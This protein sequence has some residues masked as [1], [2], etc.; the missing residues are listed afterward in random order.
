[1]PARKFDR[2]MEEECIFLR[3]ARKGKQIAGE[4]SDLDEDEDGGRNGLL[5]LLPDME[6]VKNQGMPYYHPQVSGLAFHYVPPVG[7][8]INPATTSNPKQQ[9]VPAAAA[10]LGI[11]SLE[12]IS[13]P[14]SPLPTSMSEDHRLYRTGLMMMKLFSQVA[15]GLGSGYQKKVHLDLLAGKEVVQDLYAILKGKYM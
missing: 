13:L 7:V 2:M 12:F 4:E 6:E 5:L 9:S 8:P 11:L 14:T 1:M 10:P 3:S 15:E